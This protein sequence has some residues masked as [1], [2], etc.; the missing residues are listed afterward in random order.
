[1]NPSYDARLIVDRNGAISIMLSFQQ[2]TEAEL[3]LW[4]LPI[5][6]LVPHLI[7]RR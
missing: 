3:P 6:F 2:G 1:M 4:R 7:N 5:T